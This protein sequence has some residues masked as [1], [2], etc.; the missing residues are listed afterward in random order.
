MNQSE[1]EAIA[2]N[3]HQARENA[4]DHVMIGFGLVSNWLKKWREFCYQ[5]TER[6]KAKP[7]LVP[8]Y[9]RH[10][11]EN[12]SIVG[13]YYVRP[14][15]FFTSRKKEK[16]ISFWKSRSEVTAVLRQRQKH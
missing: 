11:I 8:Q 2:C 15:Q 4:C 6:R 3:R 1:F 14:G 10:S 9:F 7:K 13:V 5:I 16:Q 12:R